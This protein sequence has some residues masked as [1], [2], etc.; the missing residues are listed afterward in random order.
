MEK[1]E[2]S[3]KVVQVIASAAERLIGYFYAGLLP[4]IILSIEKGSVVKA[5][6]EATGGVFALVCCFALG[7][8]I[9]TVYF[10]IVG[11]LL[12]YPFQHALHML[13][14]KKFSKRTSTIGLM[15][16]SGVPLWRARSAYNFVRERFLTK[17]DRADLQ[18]EHGELHVL[19]LTFV[20]TFLYFLYLEFNLD[21]AHANI[22]FLISV[23][24]Y[25]AALVGDTRQHSK[26]CA[27]LE[28]NKS[29]LDEFLLKHGLLRTPTLPYPTS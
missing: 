10:R 22:Y 26:E 14:D 1:I 21:Q 13:Y 17:E 23:V 12:L 2:L 25:I 8:G 18:V 11:E 20:I 9:Y 4:V 5:F 27:F 15:Q 28:N 6:V 24:S 3:D 16:D 7:I 29:E 19:Y